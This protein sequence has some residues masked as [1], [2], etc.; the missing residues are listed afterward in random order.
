MAP[1]NTD[2]DIK[3]ASVASAALGHLP[4]DVNAK[5][6]AL[7]LD[8]ELYGFNATQ[9]VAVAM[10]L[11]TLALE[12]DPR[13]RAEIEAIVGTGSGVVKTRHDIEI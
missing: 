7:E 3:F 6:I 11:L 4:E 2:R 1:E 12:I 9:A 13:V 8:E 5:F 10:G